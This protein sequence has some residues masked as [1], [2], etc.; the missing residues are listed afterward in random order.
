LATTST[1]R[2]GCNDEASTLSTFFWLAIFS[3]LPGFYTWYFFKKGGR[4]FES[5]FL[6]EHHHFAHALTV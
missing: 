3:F 1:A 2:E 5:K 4:E 6:S